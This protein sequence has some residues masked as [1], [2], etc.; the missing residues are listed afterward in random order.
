V[1]SSRC[2]TQPAINEILPNYQQFEVISL[3]GT[4]GMLPKLS[5]AA[6]LYIIFAFLA[7]A[8]LA[9]AGIAVVNAR[10]QAR[11]T[12]DYET[13]LVGT[14]NVERVN[15]L[16]Y[17]VVME[18]RGVYMSPDIAT[19]KKFGTGLLQFNDQIAKVVEDWKRHVHADDV[20]D[21]ETFSR[22]IAQFIEFRKE[23]V[24][25]GTEVSP[26]KGREWG[27]NDANRN[28][29]S[30]LNKD[31]DKLAANYD[32]RTK[33]IYAELEERLH[34][35]VWLLSAL[36][37]VALSLAGVGVLIIRRSVTRPLGEITH[38]TE[39][40]AGGAHDVAIPHRARPDE[41]GA[42]ARSIGVFQDAMR[43][44][45]ELNETVRRDAQAR[46]KQQENVSAEI[47]RFGA[48]IEQTIADLVNVSSQ[49]LEA[50]AHLAGAADNAASRTAGATASSEQASANVRDIAA[51]TEELS[52]SVMEIDRQVAQ[53]QS[54]AEKAIGDAE[55]TNTEIKALDEAA[56]RIGDVVKLITA[57]AEQT[58][59]LALN[60]TIEAAR[61]G[62]AGRGFAVVAQE[63]KALAGQTAKA[64]EEISAQIAG[65]QAATVR[66]VAAIG[67]IQRTIREV[68]EITTAIAAAVSEQGA[69]TRE[70][71][72]S[73]E[74]AS[75]RTI[76]TAKEVALVNAA[77]TDARDEAGS[78][79]SVSDRLGVAARSIRTQ[80]DGFFQ[81]L[82]AA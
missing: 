25:L 3:L 82:R 80:I 76:E 40:V 10:H 12:A 2:V 49:M 78:V 77:T 64:T 70:I 47:A 62:D 5:I 37:L 75:Q 74:T 26:A 29:R 53:S 32:A 38:V 44:N 46:E 48:E 13:S 21:F 31:L 59:L 34:W 16:I 11:M 6:K 22:R 9:L 8:S 58:N 66:S 36:A 57:V 23:L 35:T 81:K 17:A 56:G 69:A 42:L 27:D 7:L 4:Q 19:A 73:A 65:M 51:A 60:A 14:Q 71:A 68:G 39:A 30:A 55:K 28:V 63:V 79:K 41:I 61:A 15:G 50:S 20:A 43:R 67:A 52:A 24:R 54:I 18:S 45:V 72:R 1:E 33:R